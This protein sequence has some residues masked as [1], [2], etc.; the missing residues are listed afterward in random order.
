MQD[1]PKRSRQKKSE[2]QTQASIDEQD[3]APSGEELAKIRAYA[4]PFVDRHDED[5]DGA[6]KMFNLSLEPWR[7]WKVKPDLEPRL[8]TPP[9]TG[10]AKRIAYCRGQLDNLPIEALAR[11][12]K[13][14]GEGGIS[15]AS[16]VRYESGDTMPGA[17]E[18]RILCEALWVPANWLLFGTLD[19]TDENSPVAQIAQGL[20]RLFRQ[21]ASMGHADLIGTLESDAKT[22]EIEKRQKWMDE[23][24]KPQPRT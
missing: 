18:L 11:Y 8:A 13:N 1:K 2:E 6:V 19:E 7:M 17:R 12:T 9:E 16:L 10:I 3:Y 24:R 15:R 4:K 22:A 21:E 23:A 5:P 14:F 20:R